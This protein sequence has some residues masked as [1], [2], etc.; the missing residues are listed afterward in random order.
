MTLIEILLQYRELVRDLGRNAANEYLTR[1]CDIS[2]HVHIR[3]SVDELGDFVDA[4]GKLI[5]IEVEG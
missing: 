2:L 3:D 5:Q 4:T 1:V